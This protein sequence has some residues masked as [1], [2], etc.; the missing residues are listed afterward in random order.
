MIFLKE[1]FIRKKERKER[2]ALRSRFGVSHIKITI[3]LY[4]ITYCIHDALTHLN[5]S[6]KETGIFIQSPCECKNN[7]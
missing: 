6:M 4:S 5:R 7:L 2:F 3:Y 1:I